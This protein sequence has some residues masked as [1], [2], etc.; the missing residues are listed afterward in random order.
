M[1][2][3]CISDEGYKIAEEKRFAAVAFAAN[4]KMV[5]GLVEFALNANT[6]VTSFKK[7]HNVASRGVSIEEELHNKLKVTFWPAE[8]QMLAEF[9]QPTPWE[10]QE[11]LAKR[12]AGRLYAPYAAQFA[13]ELRKLECEKPRYC[14]NAHI[15]RV[16]EMMVL[17]SAVRANVTLMAEKIAFYERKAVED[18]DFE[19]RKQVLAQ[20]NG[21]FREAASLMAD[22]AKGFTQT[23]GN[24]L[25]G[26][27][28]ALRNLGNAWEERGNAQA[29][30]GKDPFFHQQVAA[31][32]SPAASSADSVTVSAG[33]FGNVSRNFL[34]PNAFGGGFAGTGATV[35]GKG[36]FNTLL[37]SLGSGA[38]EAQAGIGDPD[39]G[40]EKGVN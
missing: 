30:I 1:A 26:A 39:S 32:L 16:Q 29:G 19:R 20:R 8:D 21:L 24:A 10:S 9:T 25:E 7:L 3:L 14:G 18:T 37:A 27:N 28:A 35:T 4:V 33:D 34:D 12:Y 6:A 36:G 13:K 5:V 11:V 31:R 17:R 15:K 40:F 22:A 23:A 2:N 38:A